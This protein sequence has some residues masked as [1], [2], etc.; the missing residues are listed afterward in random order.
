MTGDPT[1]WSSR[2]DN[3]VLVQWEYA[4]EE[5]L[6][7]RNAIYRDLLEGANAE[8]VIADAV[9]EVSP[10]RVLDIGCGTGELAEQLSRQLG[11]DVVA[12]DLSPRMVELARERGLDA[13]R[14]D[15]EELPFADDEFDCVV[16]A[17]VIYH[18]PDR[19]RA[20]RELARVLR[21]GGR[22]V[23]ATLAE[24]NLAEVWLLLGER[25]EREISFDRENGAAQLEPY[26]ARVERRD[27]D[28]TVVFP[29]SDA[30]RTFVAASMTRAYL[31]GKV[32]DIAEPLAARYRHTVFVADKA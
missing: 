20:I 18:A 15:I 17:W 11:A 5:R 9:A 12:A 19:V 8:Q 25:W 6:R 3:P 29:D 13:R 2:L 14:A 4:S 16:A 10:Q 7:T 32:P 24:D 21:P 22:L 1:G 30:L 23:A 27:V 26:F 28:G 31:S